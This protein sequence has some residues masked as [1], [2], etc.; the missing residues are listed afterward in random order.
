MA[1]SRSLTIAFMLY[2]AR[3]LCYSTLSV[4][5]TLKMKSPTPR[6]RRL[7]MRGKKP[8]HLCM[9]LTSKQVELESPGWS[10]FVTNSKPDQT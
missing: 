2:K 3:M 6:I 5:Y 1:S 8:A 7:T 4:I 9:H 10:G